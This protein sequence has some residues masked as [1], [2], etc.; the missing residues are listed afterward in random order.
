MQKTPAFFADFASVPPWQ[1]IL[2]LLPVRQGVSTP[3]SPD[4]LKPGLKNDMFCLS[5]YIRLEFAEEP[6]TIK[7]TTAGDAP[8]E[9]K[10]QVRQ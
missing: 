10:R 8:A 4:M 1:V 6:A 3:F 2:F 5:Y 7:S 9:E